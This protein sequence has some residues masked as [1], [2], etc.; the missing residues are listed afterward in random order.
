VASQG[1]SMSR[2][3]SATLEGSTST[4]VRAKKVK[5]VH[6]ILLTALP[7]GYLT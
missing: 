1:S 4:S 3:T 6:V 2:R 5:T 7:S